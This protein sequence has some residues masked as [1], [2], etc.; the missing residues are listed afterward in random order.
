MCVVCVTNAVAI[1]YM[2]CK[3]HMIAHIAGD[4]IVYMMRNKH[5]IAHIAG[6]ALTTI[7]MV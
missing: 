6:Y 4:A 5:M 1:L 7:T 2:M 3:K